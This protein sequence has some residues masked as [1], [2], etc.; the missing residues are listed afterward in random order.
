MKISCLGD[1]NKQMHIIDAF[2]QDGL[3]YESPE[4]FSDTDS[5]SRSSQ[6]G[7]DQRNSPIQEQSDR[8]RS[9]KTLPVP[10]P[11]INIVHVSEN[12]FF[13]YNRRTSIVYLVTCS[14]T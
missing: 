12:L 7:F 8:P 13:L 4:E 3:L 9:K 6:G 11:P 10:T 14:Y 2:H 1:Q 5:D